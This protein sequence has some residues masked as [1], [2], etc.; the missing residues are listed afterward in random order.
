M[1]NPE[2]DPLLTLGLPPSATPEQ[3]RQRYLELVRQY[4][5]DRE[6]EKFREIHNAFQSFSDPLVHA[7][8]LLR[9]VREKPD[10]ESVL[11]SAAKHRPLLPKLVLLAL[12]NVEHHG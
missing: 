8:A 9:P 7:R 4:P 1:N 6:P 3:A 11:D 12:G 2:T 5:P 10:L